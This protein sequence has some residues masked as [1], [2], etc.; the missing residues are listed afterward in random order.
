MS[1]CAL[2][3]RVCTVWCMSVYYLCNACVLHVHM[4]IVCDVCLCGF[5]IAHVYLFI[6]CI[7][8]IS[9]YCA[10]NMYKYVLYMTHIY[11]CIVCVMHAKVCCV[12]CLDMRIVFDV[13]RYTY[14][15]C[16]ILRIYI[17]LQLL[18]MLYSEAGYITPAIV[19]GL[20]EPAAED[21]I[22]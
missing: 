15:A 13:L 19:C 20:Y 14:S 4:Y 2:H 3:V 7:I 21:L 17:F 18:F 16:I 9:M 12:W 22:I 8:H 1:I 5:C 11:M 10:Y 6:M